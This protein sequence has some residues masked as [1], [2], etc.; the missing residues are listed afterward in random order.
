MNAA[1]IFRTAFDPVRYRPSAF[2]PRLYTRTLHYPG[3]YDPRAGKARGLAQY[4]RPNLKLSLR[5][6]F[7]AGPLTLLSETKAEEITAFQGKSEDSGYS[8]FQ[9][10]LKLSHYDNR[11][12]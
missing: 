2:L 3:K 8:F 1:A 11:K 6:S 5:F 9:K 12:H 10:P 4:S 7:Q